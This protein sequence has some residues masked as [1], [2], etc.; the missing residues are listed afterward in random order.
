M[1]RLNYRVAILSITTSQTLH[2]LFTSQRELVLLYALAHCPS[3]LLNF[4]P[5]PSFSIQRQNE[6]EERMS[7]L[8]ASLDAC[9]QSQA[10]FT[11]VPALFDPCL[12]FTTHTP[13]ILA[14]TTKKPFNIRAT[15]NLAACPHSACHRHHLT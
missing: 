12:R 11:S 2:T 14:T 4:N 6:Q 9:I 1:T 13:S 3:F 10:I 7:Q 8:Q 5:L 15:T